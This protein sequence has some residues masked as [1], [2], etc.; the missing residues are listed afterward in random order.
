MV[1]GARRPGAPMAMDRRRRFGS[2]RTP[3]RRPGPR[4]GLHSPLRAVRTLRLLRV[5]AGSTPRARRRGPLDRDG[6]LRPVERMAR[7]SDRRGDRV[8]R[9]PRRGALLADVDVAVLLSWKEGIPRG[10]LEP[11]AHR[12]RW[13]P[14]ASRVIASRAKREE[15]F[16]TPRRPRADHRAHRPP[17]SR[18]PPA[19]PPGAAAASGCALTSMKAWWWRL[20]RSTPRCCAM[21]ASATHLLGD[22]R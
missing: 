18:I 15:R 17:C 4:R 14:G 22:S 13:L 3:A 2:L 9:L 12:S 10:L 1:R 16:L 20:A 7:S 11:M 19:P 8:R 5:F 6:P 21:P